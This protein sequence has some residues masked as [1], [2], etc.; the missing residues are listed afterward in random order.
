MGSFGPAIGAILITFIIKGQDGFKRLIKL[1]IQWKVPIWLY[2]YALFLIIVLYTVAILITGIFDFSLL[3]FGTLPR[4]SELIKYFILIL[5]VGG[6][7]GEEIGWRGFLQPE[8]QKKYNPVIASIIIG[9]IWLCWHL[10]LFWLE[11]TAQQGG[12]I[13][14]FSLNIFAMTFLFTWLYF[15]TSGSLLLAVLFHTSINLVSALIIP[16]LFP[17]IWYSNYFGII[18]TMVLAGTAIYFA[19]RLKKE[20]ISR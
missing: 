17:S 12:S 10:P 2:L 18:F 3:T 6:P 8:L 14:L 4:F 11:G 9:V 20:F 15:K 5:I 1:L 19:F 13:V 7:L 16:G